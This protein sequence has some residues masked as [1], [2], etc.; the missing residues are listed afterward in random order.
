MSK[1]MLCWSDVELAGKQ[2]K[3]RIAYDNPARR[4]TSSRLR[5]IY[6]D[7]PQIGVHN[8]PNRNTDPYS[9]SYF[10]S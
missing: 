3:L 2:C 5:H 8:S 10:A 7:P 9:S 1:T 4:R 6:A